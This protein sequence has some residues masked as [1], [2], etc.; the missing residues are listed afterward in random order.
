M[1]LLWLVLI[2]FSS[3]S[4]A[5][6]ELS[7]D[8]E[9][10]P[11]QQDDLRNCCD[12]PQRWNLYSIE[13]VCRSACLSKEQKVDYECFMDCFLRRTDLV[14]KDKIEEVAVTEMYSVGY[15]VWADVLQAAIEK[16]E[17]ESSG[18]LTDKLLKYFNCIDDHMED[19]CATFLPSDEC[20]SVELRFKTC[21]G[22]VKYN[23]ASWPSELGNPES[24]C[25]APQLVPIKKIKTC[26]RECKRKE[27]FEFRRTECV[28]NC[29]WYES[30]IM[31]NDGIV[32]YEKVKTI[33]IENSNKS[34]NWEKSIENAVEGCRNMSG[35][36]NP[37]FELIEVL[38]SF[39]FASTGSAEP[40]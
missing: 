17:Y 10:W 9:N 8:C 31:T 34:V 3:W 21:H 28:E 13:E 22:G 16:C 5:L 26:Q 24:C 18:S 25:Y 39:F 35:G 20:N 4:F 15:T 11:T 7:G 1:K 38:I 40:S 14:S 27:L 23:C 37:Y 19:N 29:T 12:I 32:D 2:N 33:L 30:G 36:K 6:S